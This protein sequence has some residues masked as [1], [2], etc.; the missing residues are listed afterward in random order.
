MPP[1]P[2]D[3]LGIF[4][5]SF[6][7]FDYYKTV[8]INIW[9]CTRCNQHQLGAGDEVGRGEE[10]ERYPGEQREEGA[11]RSPEQVQQGEGGHPLKVKTRQPTTLTKSEH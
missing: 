2:W 1:L 11:E 7:F 5:F 3:A 10:E 4:F 8:T 9:C 6:N